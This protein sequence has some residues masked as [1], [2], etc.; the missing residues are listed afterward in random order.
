MV[1]VNQAN[2]GGQQAKAF[3]RYFSLLDLHF[4]SILVDSR[5]EAF[6]TG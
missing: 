1:E 5:F 4:F 6:I 3:G 2:G